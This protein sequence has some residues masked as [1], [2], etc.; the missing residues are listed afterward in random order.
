MRRVAFFLFLPALVLF[1]LFLP[2]TPRGLG[3]HPHPA[4]NYAAAL[5][6]VAAL[7]RADGPDIAKECRSALYEHGRRVGN[8]VLVFH[9]LTNCPAQ[10]DSLARIAYARGAN[11]YVPR[12]PRHGFANRMTDEL[13]KSDA[14]E[15]VQ[16]ADRACDA[17]SGLGDTLTVVGLSVGGTLAA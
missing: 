9:G 3:S 4:R 12:L 15:L 17:A 7:G 13:G 6:S 5:D 10:F 8:V 16:F 11:V 2:L 14:R 1:V